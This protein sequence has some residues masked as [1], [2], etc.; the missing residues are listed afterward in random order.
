MN[1]I[2]AN[3]E[4]FDKILSLPK[5]IIDFWAPWCGPCRMLAPVLEEIAEEKSD[6]QIV[7]INVDDNPDL[8]VKYNIS[9]I[10]A[11]LYFENGIL[12]TQTLGYMEKD[13]LLTKLNIK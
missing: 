10:P 4:S 11:I 7:K 6:V 1:I 2:H 8:A 3:K 12:K 5:V 13:Q 9:S